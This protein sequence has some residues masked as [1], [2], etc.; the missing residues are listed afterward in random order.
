MTLPRAVSPALTLAGQPARRA[1]AMVLT[2]RDP[3]NPGRR[4]QRLVR[5]RHKIAALAPRTRLPTIAYLNGRVI[6]RKEW[7]RRVA[8][9]DVVAFVTLPLGG[10]GE[11]NPLQMVA[12]IALMVYAPQMAAA[13]WAEA[14]AIQIVGSI[15]LNTI[16]SGIISMAGN[17]LIGAAFAGKPAEPSPMAQSMMATPSPTYNINA[18]GNMAR[19]NAAIPVQ[20]GKM[21]AYPDFAAQPYA[22]F[23]GNEQYLFQLLCLGQGYY[24]IESIRI[25]DTSI[26][27]FAEIDYEI[28][29]PGGTLTLFPASVVTSTEVAGQEAV[30]DTWLGPFVAN[31]AGTTANTLAVDVVCPRGLF[32]ANDSGGLSTTSLSFTVEARLI[33]SGGAPLGSY[34]TLGTE[35]LSAGTNTPQRYSFRYSGLSGRYEVRLKRTT[36]AGGTTRY[37]DDLMWAG[38]RAYLPETRSWAGQTVIALRMRAS[39]NLSGQASRKINVICTRKLPIYSGGVWT[40]PQVTRSPAWALADTLRASYGGGL[41]DDR[42]D[43]AQ[44]TT[45]AATYAARGDTFDA[46]FDSALTLWE[47]VNRIGQAVRTKPYQ[48]GG[49]VHFVRDEAASVPVALFSMRNIVRGSFSIDYLMPTDDTADA[50]D[51]GYFD[52]TVWSP[53]RVT[54]SLPGSSEAVPLKMELFGVTQRQQA[55]QEGVYLAAVNRYRRKRISFQTEM[56]GFIPAFGDLIAIAHDMPAWGTSGEVIGYNAGTKVISLSEPVTFGGG[57][58]YIGLRKRNGSI[59]GPYVVTAG[60]DAYQVVHT[61]ATI[62]DTPYTGGAEERTH[63]AF[64]AGETWRQPARVVAVKPSGLNRVTIEAINEDASVHTADTGVTAPAAQYSNLVSLYTAPVVAGL[65]ARSQVDDPTV[66]LVSWQAAPG[67]RFYIVD[68]SS[69]GDV[70]TRVGETTGNNTTIA[71]VYGNGTLIRVAAFGFTLGPSIQIAYATYSDYMWAVPDTGLMWSATS[72]DLMWSA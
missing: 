4:T 62:D 52:G 11:K 63:F 37:G 71:A 43:I 23:A 50:L 29:D 26:S 61:A 2:L 67:A 9:G 10:D 55:Y 48:Q 3:F 49:V 46:R 6:L 15:T 24:E 8:P 44:L 5:R 35:T 36:T 25:E 57:D 22:E 17:A 64:G 72:T 47:A 27:S 68:V 38:L 14:G 69:D 12:M 51:V 42:I 18:Q 66:I 33:D 32:Y 58:H 34:V 70:W 39:N 20:Y 19:I 21:M 53:R 7:H 65:T 40:S 45:L 30:Y 59:S 31:A 28:I 54:A 60:A 56:E 13:M 16:T 1:G 41:S